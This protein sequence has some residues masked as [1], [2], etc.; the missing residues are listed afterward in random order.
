MAGFLKTFGYVQSVKNDLS[1][2]EARTASDSVS[3]WDFVKRMRYKG[4]L[5]RISALTHEGCSELVRAV[6]EHVKAQ[7]VQE[8]PPVAEVDPR[9][10]E[11][12]G[13]GQ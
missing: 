9:F 13:T 7:K 12:E 6:Y 3:P 8:Q 1:H 5:F 2:T 4:P 11:G 10:T